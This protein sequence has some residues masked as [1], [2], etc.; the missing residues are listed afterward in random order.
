MAAVSPLDTSELRLRW[1]IV[2]LWTLPAEEL[3]ATEDPGVMPWVPLTRF[4]GP[5]EP[6]FRR[7]SEVIRSAAPER[8]RANLLAVT[9]VLARLRYNDPTLFSLLGGRV[10]MIESPLL[11]EIRAEGEARGEALSILRVLRIR[12][13]TVSEELERQVMDLQDRLRLETLLD[14]AA[15]GADLGEFV[16]KLRE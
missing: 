13:G 16:R 4:E 2:E 3:L 12:F 11:D 7:C 10:T 15:T 1:R 6:I 14:T 8:E 9:Q 5:P